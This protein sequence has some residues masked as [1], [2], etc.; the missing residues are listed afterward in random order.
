MSKL[1]FRGS[2]FREKKTVWEPSNVC[3]LPHWR[4]TW[5]PVVQLMAAN[6]NNFS[7]GLPTL[8]RSRLS[9]IHKSDGDYLSH[10]I[11]A[12]QEKHSFSR[13]LTGI[14]SK[15]LRTHDNRKS[16]KNL[17]MMTGR[18]IVVPDLCYKRWLGPS[19]RH[20]EQ[21]SSALQLK[22]FPKE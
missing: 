6:K 1:C 7:F 11:S 15:S 8:H 16:G 5:L 9:R 19:P 2:F 14:L 22:L 10:L 17:I 13:N 4:S 3:K 21:P 12:T 18:L 20:L